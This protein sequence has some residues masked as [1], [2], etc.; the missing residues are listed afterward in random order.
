MWQKWIVLVVLLGWADQR[1]SAATLSFAA[2]EFVPFVSV[3]DG[4]PTGAVTDIVRQACREANIDCSFKVQSWKESK[5]AVEAGTLDGLFVV[6]WERER[7]QWLSFS[8]PLLHTEWGY[9]VPASD[10]RAYDGLKSLGGYRI[11]VFGPSSSSETLE[12]VKPV[13]NL[14]IQLSQDDLANVRRLLAGELDAVYMNRDVAL[15]LLQRN[16]LQDQVR[17]VMG[18]SGRNYHLAFSKQA[19]VQLVG[20]F[21]RALRRMFKAREVQQLLSS[22]QLEPARWTSTYEP[23]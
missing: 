16:G 9:L 19:D 18:D 1:L 5:A 11:G 15:S 4:Q 3:K 10:S 17:Y 23:K 21:N 2:A 8:L 7:A 20:P 22:Q 6:S 13:L 14:D 12:R